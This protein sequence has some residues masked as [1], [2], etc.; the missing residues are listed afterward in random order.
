MEKNFKA[1]DVDRVII[2]GGAAILADDA[3][4]KG[5]QQHDIIQEI[6]LK[7]NRMKITPEQNTE[8]LCEI[9]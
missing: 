9:T 8:Y 1:S 3:L 5:I 6:R 2:G 7:D 4:G